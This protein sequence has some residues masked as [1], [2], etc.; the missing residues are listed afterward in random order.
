M[1]RPM[2]WGLALTLVVLAALPARAD[3]TNNYSIN[4]SS[5]ALLVSRT[6]SVVIDQKNPKQTRYVQAP[7]PLIYAPVRTEVQATLLRPEAASSFAQ[8]TAGL[9]R[10]ATYIVHSE[11]IYSP[12]TVESQVEAGSTALMIDTIQAGGPGILPGARMRYTVGIDISGSFERLGANGPVSSAASLNV[13]LK[14]WATYQRGELSWAAAVRGTGHFEFYLDTFAGNYLELYSSLST[15]AYGG[16]SVGA[17]AS[18]DL[19][20]TVRMTLTPSIAGANT[21]GASGFNYAVS[22][23]PETSSWAMLVSGLLTLGWVYR[24]RAQR[25]LDGLEDRKLKHPP[26]RG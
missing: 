14:D 15:S 18:A 5:Q 7:D 4:L 21:L 6:G 22:A 24:G 17:N 26:S 1:K 25:R 23:V 3:Y 11:T 10:S 20:H 2:H 9:L 13:I 16:G 12:V 19:S 8:A